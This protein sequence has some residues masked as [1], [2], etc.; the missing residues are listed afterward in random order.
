MFENK[1]KTKQQKRES[2]IR[3][4]KRKSEKK[5]KKAATTKQ[6][7]E[8]NIY[9]IVVIDIAFT[10]N[11]SAYNM[12]FCVYFVAALNLRYLLEREDETKKEIQQQ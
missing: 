10:I 3:A 6:K 4:Q 1:K 8:L 5:K 7:K 9:G 12:Y 2:H 11:A